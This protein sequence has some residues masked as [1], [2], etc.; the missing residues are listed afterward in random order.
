MTTIRCSVCNKPLSAQHCADCGESIIAPEH[1]D[2]QEEHSRGKRRETAVLAHIP[3]H[4]DTLKLPLLDLVGGDSGDTPSENAINETPPELVASSARR[5]RSGVQTAPAKKERRR[6]GN[7]RPVDDD[8]SVLDLPA[9]WHKE[10]APNRSKATP[11]PP[12]PT[13]SRVRLLNGKRGHSWLR[14]LPPTIFMW[15]S[16]LVLL[17]VVFSGIFGIVAT[18]SKG[19]NNVAPSDELSLQV[20]PSSVFVGATVVLKGVHFSPHGRISL[21]RDNAIPIVDTSD[22]SITSADGHGNFSDTVAIA[23]DWGSGQHTI[24]AEDAARHKVASFSILVTGY[25]TS[26]RPAHL[27]IPINSLDLGAGDQLTNTVKTITLANV[28]GGQITWQGSS[29]QPWLILSPSSGTFSSGQSVQVSVAIDRSKLKPGHYNAQIDFLSNA[30]RSTISAS[31]EVTQLLPDHMAMLQITPALLSFTATDGSVSPPEQTVTVS[32]PGLQP[33]Q[34]QA[35]SSASWLY[36]TPQSTQVDPSGSIPVAIGVDTRNLLPGTYSGVVTFGAQGVAIASPQSLQVTV[37]VVPQCSLQFSPGMLNFASEYQRSAP[38]SET[39]TLGSN[40]NCSA[41]IAWRAVSNAHWLTISANS[42]AAPS[43]P[44]IGINPAGLTPGVYTSSIL[45]SSAAGTQTFPVTFTLGKTTG[46]LVTSAPGAV[47]FNS[48][49]GQSNQVSQQISIINKGSGGSLTWQATTATA[50]G[51]NWLAVSPASGTLAPHKPATLSITVKNFSTLTSGTYRGTITITGID[52]VGSQVLGSPQTIPIN[53]VVQ[54]NCA[55]VTTPAGLSFMRTTGVTGYASQS[56]AILTNT[57]CADP[58]SWTAT[59]VTDSGS[60][61]LSATSA[62][63]VGPYNN[64]KIAV[65]V[66]SSALGTGSYTGKVIVTA[67]DIITKQVVGQPHVVPVA[68]SVLAPP[69]VCTLQAPSSSQ[70]HFTTYVDASPAAQSFTIATSGTCGGAISI[71]PTVRFSSRA[72]WLTVGPGSVSISAGGVATFTAGIASASLPAGT[73]TAYISL[74]AKNNGAAL[75]NSPRTVKVIL[76]VI[77]RPSVQKP[78]TPAPVQ[79]T[80]SP[81]PSPTATA[82]PAAST[83]SS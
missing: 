23:P 3:Q 22:A 61:W 37:T 82:S 73:Y 25:A 35:T 62:G 9:T 13:R 40:A 52:E 63:K 7:R 78:P 34:W 24:N 2:T 42:G 77:K 66:T 46:P 60:N 17:V 72:G 5:T 74:R 53:L 83:A 19:I 32:N 68:L 41:P 51:G 48:T 30:G 44:V 39:I 59:A 80:P 49:G 28:G 38:A 45:F 8:W 10:V 33:L 26:L 56:V 71:T 50:T 20:N 36:V 69:P 14:A 4:A 75:I 67:T 31:A 57:T 64:G 70:E 27:F 16:V 12:R 1:K 15:V 76:Q 29:T 65:S 81:T 58:L 6:S 43:T 54:S 47:V 21:S 55:I 18:R 79:S 11:L